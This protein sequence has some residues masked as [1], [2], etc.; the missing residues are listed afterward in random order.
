MGL[1][2]AQHIQVQDQLKDQQEL[3]V[4]QKELSKRKLAQYITAENEEAPSNM[5]NKSQNP[6]S[7]PMITRSMMRQTQMQPN[8]VGGSVTNMGYVN[9]GASLES[10]NMSSPRNISLGGS[11]ESLTGQQMEMMN[12]NRMTTITPSSSGSS[13]SLFS[14]ASSGRIRGQLNPMQLTNR[15]SRVQTQRALNNFDEYERTPLLPLSRELRVNLV[16]MENL[17]GAPRV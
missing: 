5:F 13:N 8:P 9:R 1:Q 6:V 11:Y 12:R 7:I 2:I 10:I 15:L 14:A 17:E 4:L 16:R 3:I